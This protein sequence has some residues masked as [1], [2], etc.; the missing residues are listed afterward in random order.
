MLICVPIYVIIGIILIYCEYDIK[1][2]LIIIPILGAIIPVI[3][4]MPLSN[5]I[6]NFKDLR[7]LK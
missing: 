3:L 2:K 6:D 1:E 7:P 4:T 5:V